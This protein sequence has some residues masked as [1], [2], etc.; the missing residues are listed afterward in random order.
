MHG[1]S[2]NDTS[3]AVLDTGHHLHASASSSEVCDKLCLR[4]MHQRT[5]L[6]LSLTVQ[7]I[8]FQF[9]CL[10]SSCVCLQHKPIEFKVPAASEADM[11]V[12]R[13]LA[14]EDRTESHK[15]RHADQH[16]SRLPP[17]AE[18][19]AKHAQHDVKSH[20]ERDRSR[21]R[22]SGK[23]EASEAKRAE[24]EHRDSR[25]ARVEPKHAQRE[26]K[27][28]LDRAK[29]DAERAREQRSKEPSRHRE[30]DRDEPSRH[31]DSDRERRRTSPSRRHSLGR[32]G[33]L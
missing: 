14:S 1:W 6:D 13:R 17:S 32:C 19:E 4:P 5:L 31:R 9:I 2:H 11:S 24:H 12:E 10:T 21:A 22:D 29:R 23:S 8:V 16:P 7:G 26:S 25:T 20:A 18:S 3:T 30:A 33:V 28:E 27:Y 15:S